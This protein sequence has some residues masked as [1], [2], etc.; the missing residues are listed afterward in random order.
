MTDPL[1]REKLLFLPPWKAL[2]ASGCW[3]LETPRSLGAYLLEN[4]LTASRYL[5]LTSSFLDAKITL[6][7]SAYEKNAVLNERFEGFQKDNV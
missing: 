3:A 6:A 1:S 2:K 5:P 4:A 7:S